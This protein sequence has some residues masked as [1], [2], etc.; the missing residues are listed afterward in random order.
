MREIKFRA[1]HKELKRFAP[2]HASIQ[3]GGGEPHV[4]FDGF[5]GN[6]YTDVWYLSDC[7][8]LQYTGIEDKNGTEIYEGD[9]L[10]C[11]GD[12]SIV[13]FNAKNFGGVIGWN[14]LDREGE[15]REYYYGRTPSEEEEVI[16]NIYENPE[17]LK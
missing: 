17:L 7:V 8:L 6:F 16:G 9:I 12:V 4:A 15:A 1:W 10:K 5:D 13:S 2:D 3:I 14:L 11:F